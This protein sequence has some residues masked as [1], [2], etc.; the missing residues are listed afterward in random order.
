VSCSA[1]TAGTSAPLRGKLRAVSSALHE[2][3]LHAPSVS[4][5]RRQDSRWAYPLWGVLLVSVFVLY[6]TTVLLVWNTPRKSLAK[7]FHTSFLEAVKGNEYFRG[8]RMTQSWEMFAPNPT[9]TNNFVHVYV[10]DRHGQDW[11]F[12]QDIWEENRYPYFW[13]DRRGKVN[14]RIDNKKEFQRQY[15]AWVCREWERTHDGEAAKSVS[16]VRRITK[17]PEAR[18]VIANGGWD[19]WQAPSKLTEQETVTC[20]VIPHGTLP[21]ELRE[22]YGL[23]LLEDEKQFMPVKI[24]TWWDK[25]EQERVRAE[26]DAQREEPS[27]EEDSPDQ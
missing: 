9:T 1:Q 26:R 12:E 3:L 16:F 22:R 11:D 10:R 19:Q 25:Q 24:Q 6:T 4:S 17:V 8:T 21:N 15:G 23:P 14:R 18:E 2:S 13:Y 27:S 5:D 20:K 7:E